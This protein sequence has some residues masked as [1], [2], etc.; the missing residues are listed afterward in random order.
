M[1]MEYALIG[2][3]IAIVIPVYVITNRIKIKR[4]IVKCIA[5]K[6]GRKSSEQ[7]KADE[8]ISVSSYYVNVKQQKHNDFFID[9]ITWNDLDM[10]KVFSRICNT[11][12]TVGE[13]YLYALLRQP[14][15]EKPVLDDRNRLIEFFKNNPVQRENILFLLARLG[16]KRFTNISDYFYTDKKPISLR[17]LYYKLLTSILI[18]SPLTMIINVELGLFLLIASFITNMTVYYKAKNNISSYLE[19]LSYIVNLIGC[20][21]KISGLHI[22]EI[23]KYNNIL[24]ASTEKL[25]KTAVKSFYVLF[26]KT[27]DPFLE[28]IKVVFLG[29]LIAFESLLKIIYKNSEHLKNIYEI[30]GLLDSMISIA[31][32]RESISYYTTPDLF[33]CTDLKTKR[34]KFADIY[35][36]L[37]NEPVVNSVQINK[38]VLITGSNASGKSTFLKTVAINA[39]FAQTIYTC[40]SK[41]Y[42][43]CFFMI[44][45]SMALK[46]NLLNNESY[47]IAEIKSLKRIFDSINDDLPCLCFIDEVLRGTNTVE[48]IAAS[49]EI[50]F[51]LSCSN[52]L[53]VAAT[54]DIEL[55]SILVHYFDNY[56]FQEHFTEN[57]IVFDYKIY[58]GK[59]NTRN[60]IKLLKFIGY[61][62]AIVNSAEKNAETFTINGKWEKISS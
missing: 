8:L 49:S 26:Y 61:R 16:K 25:S 33:K 53:C 48:R 29:E 42:S 1:I 17:G 52:S 43:S 50:L 39:I 28:Y 5:E 27:E 11:F 14:L 56:H 34:L 40:L 46:D 57:E 55:T 21:R 7:F 23:E 19:S 37:I 31:S 9:D 38:P 6:W 22:P 12:S 15:F 20:A 54:H 59:S 4:K 2:V 44:F 32:Y 36:P 45:S 41:N 58:P 18:L 24:K 30:V 13:E 3:L 62:D 60:A 35:H 47:Y 10:D 51:N